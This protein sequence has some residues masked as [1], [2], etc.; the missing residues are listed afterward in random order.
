MDAFVTRK[1]PRDS[2]LSQKS[3]GKRDPSISPP[4]KRNAPRFSDKADAEPIDLTDI[5]SPKSIADV[6]RPPAAEASPKVLPSPVQLNFVKDLP[7]SNNVDTIKLN[8]VLGDPMIKECWL[9]N[10]L[11]D[12]DFIMCARCS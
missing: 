11:F 2:D 1:R 3:N 10:Y 8:D 5:E 9:F 7:S 12:I 4:P 6:G